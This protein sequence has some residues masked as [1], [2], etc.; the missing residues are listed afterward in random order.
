MPTDGIVLVMGPRLKTRMG[1]KATTMM[2]V[3]PAT[4]SYK[5]TELNVSAICPLDYEEAGLIVDDDSKFP[6]SI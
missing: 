5:C 2:R 4:L 1:M 3:S 6:R